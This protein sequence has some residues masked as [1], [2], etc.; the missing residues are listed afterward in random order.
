MFYSSF[1]LLLLWLS[2]DLVINEITQTTQADSR[3]YAYHS[4]FRIDF[5]HE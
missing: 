2:T 4:A 5:E 3:V 1:F